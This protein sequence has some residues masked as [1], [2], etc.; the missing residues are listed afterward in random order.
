MCLDVW[1]VFRNSEHVKRRVKPT[2]PVLSLEIRTFQRGENLRFSLTRP[3]KL[4]Y[5][6]IQLNLLRE[7]SFERNHVTRR[8]SVLRHCKILSVP[9]II[10]CVQVHY[11]HERYDTE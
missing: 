10:Y 5:I 7:P 1:M 2:N 3:D 9:Q 6:G 8:R 4:N 11:L